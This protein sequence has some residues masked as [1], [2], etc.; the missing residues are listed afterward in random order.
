MYQFAFVTAENYH[1]SAALSCFFCQS[2]TKSA[3]SSGN[4]GKT[5]VVI[6]TGHI[7]K[8]EKVLYLYYCLAAFILNCFSINVR[9]LDGSFAWSKESYFAKA[10]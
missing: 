7:V 5:G 4:D 6:S 9:A 3:S 2:H 10:S 1:L 8:I